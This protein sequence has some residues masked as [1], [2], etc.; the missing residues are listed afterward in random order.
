MT[1]FYNSRDHCIIEF[2][3]I[4]TNHF[5][6]LGVLECESTCKHLLCNV[7]VFDKLLALLPLM[8]DQKKS[9]RLIFFLKTVRYL[10]VF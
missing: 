2:S 9:L 3:V 10:E 1:K 8:P 5:F 4:I 7:R 6:S